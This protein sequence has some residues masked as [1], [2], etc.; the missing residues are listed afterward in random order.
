MKMNRPQYLGIYM[1][2]VFLLLLAA[3]I[4]QVKIGHAPADF[5]FVVIFPFALGLIF[6]RKWAYT[7][8]VV[9]GIAVTS[10]AL[11]AS[12]YYS[13]AALESLTIGCGPIVL[14]EPGFF[15]LWTFVF[16]IILLL[17]LPM[18]SLLANDFWR[19][20]NKSPKA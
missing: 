7:G 3:S 4:W 6:C 16:G 13:Y 1:L 8:T 18:A 10:L 2:S 11:I 12:V 9:L 15:A 14:V 17:G 19:R 5:S 20:G